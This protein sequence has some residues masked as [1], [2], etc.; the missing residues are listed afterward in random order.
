MNTEETKNTPPPPPLSESEAAFLEWVKQS[1]YA[2]HFH[3]ERKAFCAG[4]AAAM[5]QRW[6]ERND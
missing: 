4:W 5:R 2:A 6:R 1:H 3:I